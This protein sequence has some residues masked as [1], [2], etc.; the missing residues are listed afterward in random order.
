LGLSAT[1]AGLLLS[2]VA[3]SVPSVEPDALARDEKEAPGKIRT[4]RS[5][6]VRG[7]RAARRDRVLA[8]VTE[9]APWPSKMIEP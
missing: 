7:R 9:R 8:F 1:Q 6:F 4:R 2:R 5:L 3:A